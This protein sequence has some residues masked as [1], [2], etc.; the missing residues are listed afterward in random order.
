MSSKGKL[1]QAYGDLMDDDLALTKAGKTS[2]SVA[3]KETGKNK[4]E[5]QRAISDASV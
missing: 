2:S 3:S 1:K 4:E 5:I